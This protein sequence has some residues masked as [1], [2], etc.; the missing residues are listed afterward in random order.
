MKKI[1]RTCQVKKKLVQLYNSPQEVESVMES[2]VD[3]I[4]SWTTSVNTY[5]QIVE[6]VFEFVSHKYD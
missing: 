2:A 6:D 3:T 5:H 1:T 4:K